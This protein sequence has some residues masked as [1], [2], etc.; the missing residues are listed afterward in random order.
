MPAC[1]LS[2]VC[3]IRYNT[4]MDTADELFNTSQEKFI[5]QKVFHDR[6]KLLNDNLLVTS[7]PAA[8]LCATILFFGL[9]SVSNKSMLITWY[10]S[11]LIV[12]L[13]RFY[14]ISLYRRYP[15]AVRYHMNVFIFGTILSALTWGAAGSM[16]IPAHNIS[17]LM[18]AIIIVAGITA[19]GTQTLQASRTANMSFIVIAV[20]PM[21]VWLLAQEEHV[22]FVLSFAVFAYMAFML[23]LAQRGYTQLLESIRLR[24]VNEMLVGQLFEINSNL[25]DEISERKKTQSQ[26]D[27]LV[28][29]DV[30][31][32]VANR[33]AFNIQ[34]NQTLG[35]AHRN[36]SQFSL[37]Y[38]D[39]DNF[40]IINDSF[41]HDVG[42]RVLQ[43]IAA[44]LK[45]NLR[46]IDM[47][48]RIGGDE[49]IVVLEETHGREYVEKFTHRIKSLFRQSFEVGQH[50]IQV[51]LS[52]GACIFPD[53]GV[54]INSLM[55]NA[56]IALYHAKKMGRNRTEFYRAVS[57]ADG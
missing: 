42:D 12:S 14:Q 24:H 11:V 19:G 43:V 39:V 46:E 20:L 10:A 13:F 28:T 6:V 55:K 32:K 21:A 40:K 29:H 37:L 38:I 17:H 36:S 16:L 5:E 26:L 47:L 22:Y 53:D 4:L 54:D 57:H 50:Q 15:G 33:H 23:M 25:V 45:E 48:A 51:T 56:D 18:L 35:R 8:L 34:F 52:I 30:L 41:G 3:E 31:T 1:R 9:Y 27:Y 44:R 49:F 7:L 2:L